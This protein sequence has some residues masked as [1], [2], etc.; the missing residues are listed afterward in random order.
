METGLEL[1]GG[2]LR[3][4]QGK[5]VI[6]MDIC[7]LTS[8]GKSII[9]RSDLSTEVCSSD[10]CL[11]FSVF[12]LALSVFFVCLLLFVFFFFFFLCSF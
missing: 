12:F 1:R 6:Q 7:M 8:L 4:A 3:A 10:L 2:I 9:L 5:G 11:F